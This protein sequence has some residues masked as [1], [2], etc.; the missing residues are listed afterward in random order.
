MQPEVIAVVRSAKAASGPPE[1]VGTGYQPAIQRPRKHSSGKYLNENPRHGSCRGSSAAI[2]VPILLKG[3]AGVHSDRKR[4]PAGIP[5]G[6]LD[7]Q[8][9]LAMK[10][11][12]S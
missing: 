11:V 8:N 1:N 9:L 12:D 5:M 3:K 4:H 6:N 2:S 10:L 7:V